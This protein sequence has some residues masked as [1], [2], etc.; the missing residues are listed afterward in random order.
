MLPMSTITDLLARCHAL[1]TDLKVA[2]DG[3]RNTSARGLVVH[4]LTG[5]E[6]QVLFV[7]GSG[8][9]LGTLTAEGL[10]VLRLDGLRGLRAAHSRPGDDVR[11]AALV[12]H[13]H[14]GAHGGHPSLVTR[15]AGHSRP[16][17]RRPLQRRRLQRALPVMPHGREP[18]RPHL[19]EARGLGSN[20]AGRGP[21]ALRI[22]LPIAE[23]GGADATCGRH[24][25]W[26][27]LSGADAVGHIP[28]RDPPA[29]V[30]CPDCTDTGRRP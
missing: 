13:C 15:R 5:R 9:E 20:R 24:R 17:R 28:G 12:A 8:G 2:N 26:W 21:H 19:R 30:C 6:P 25:H 11:L 22:V 16:G 27:W 10:A 29:A 18:A 1:D 4:P 3:R 23:P 14:F 7:K